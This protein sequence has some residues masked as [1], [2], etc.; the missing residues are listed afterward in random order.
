MSSNINSGPIDS[1]PLVKRHIVSE[2]SISNV[3]GLRRMV[4]LGSF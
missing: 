1:L 4:I 2:V 3:V